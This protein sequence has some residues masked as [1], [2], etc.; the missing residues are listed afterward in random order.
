LS[1]L[2]GGHD[3]AGRS[4]RDGG[5]VIDLRDLNAVDIDPVRR[6]ATVGGGALSR[7]VVTA[8]A[9][10]GLVAWPAFWFRSARTGKSMPKRLAR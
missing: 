3:W 10:H 5:L 7:D 9:A 2:G 1:V 8:A 4:V 6:I